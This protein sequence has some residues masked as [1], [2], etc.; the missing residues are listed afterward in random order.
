MALNNECFFCGL[1]IEDKVSREHVF[2][3]AF[4]KYLDLKVEKFG[5]SLP[6]P[7]EY[8]R[9]KVPAHRVCN[10]EAGAW[11]ENYVLGILKSMDANPDHLSRLHIQTDDSVNVALRQVLTQWLA[12]LYYGLL[13]WE[14]VRKYHPDNVYQRQLKAMLDDRVFTHLRRCFVD[15]IGF[16]VPSSL[17]YF[18]VPNPPAPVFR[19]D[20]GNGLPYGLFY[21]RF[22]N[23]LLI[24]ALGDA[25]LVSE[26]LTSD[27][28]ASLQT[29][30]DEESAS[31]PVAYLVA[32][33]HCWAVRENLPVQPRLEYGCDYIHDRSAEGLALKPPINGNSV[34]ARAVELFT[35]LARKWQLT[36]GRVP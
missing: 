14:C 13:Y 17:F 36:G 12:K 18:R 23:H 27:L 34:N 25:C 8:S 32:V 28:V 26:W 2:G 11:F 9:L 6:N 19:F 21:L 31:D 29:T 1:E 5:S 30:I 10:N 4:L 24:A 3:N 16:N 33:A 20:F 15:D 35:E 22:D 7:V